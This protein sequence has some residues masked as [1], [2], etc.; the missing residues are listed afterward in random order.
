MNV[1]IE[2]TTSQRNLRTVS[3]FCDENPAFTEGGMR[4]QI[5]NENQN[6]LAA[7]GAIVRMG[8]RVL[9]DVDRFFIWLDSQQSAA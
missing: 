4:W 1:N 7:C 3:Q 9:I 5:F 8:R 6:G 2:R